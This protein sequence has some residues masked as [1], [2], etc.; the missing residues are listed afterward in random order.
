MTPEGEKR[1]AWKRGTD[2]WENRNL[3][4]RCI[5]RGA[6]RRPSG[7]NNNYMILQAPGHVVIVQEMIHDVRFIALDGRPHLDPNIRLWLGDSRGRWEGETLVVE[8]TNFNDKIAFNSFNCCEGAGQ[9]LRI[10]ERFTRVSADTIDYQYTVDDPTTYVR[11]WTASIPMSKTQGPVF[12]YACHEG[13]HAIANILRTARA[14][15]EDEDEAA[16]EATTR[17]R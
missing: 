5:T 7:Y 13:N 3:A 11:A 8:T 2:S 15:D 17:S 10:V 1:A 14:Q 12:E 6:P 4:E 16:V 9:G